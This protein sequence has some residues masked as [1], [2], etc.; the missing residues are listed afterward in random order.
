MIVLIIVVYVHERETN[1]SI[2][3][4]YSIYNKISSLSHV[5]TALCKEIFAV[6]LCG[7]FSKFYLL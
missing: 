7:K 6:A 2:F 1:V 4:I 5:T 3:T